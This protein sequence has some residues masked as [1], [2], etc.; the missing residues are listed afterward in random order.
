MKLEPRERRTASN[1]LIDNADSLGLGDMY[2]GW[3]KKNG[4]DS[5]GKGTKRPTATSKEAAARKAPAKSPKKEKK[6]A[7]V[8]KE[9]VKKRL[10][11]VAKKA[12]VAKKPAVKAPAPAPAPAPAA[13]GRKTTQKKVSAAALQK[14]PAP[15]AKPAAKTDGPAFL[16]L[17]PVPASYQVPTPQAAEAGA[18][19][20]LVTPLVRFFNNR[21]MRVSVSLAAT[22]ADL[23][24]QLFSSLHP[25]E[26]MDRAPML[27]IDGRH[28][29]PDGATLG[30]VGVTD[31]SVIYHFS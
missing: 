14:Q 25:G 7:A 26:L 8:K 16:R 4:K 31:D 11:A 12:P 22:V 29:A 24:L 30:E 27:V 17:P 10:L 13:K 21:M 6:V 1:Y 23:K 28:D 2:L 18:G 15:T 5:R 9:T 3:G 19:A 20:L